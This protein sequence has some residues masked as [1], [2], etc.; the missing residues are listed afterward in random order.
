ME[1]VRLE[2]DDPRPPL[3]CGDP[4]LDE[5]YAVD[6]I[7]GCRELLSVTYVFCEDSAAIA[8][9]SLSND[10]IKKEEVPRSSFERLQKALKRE[11]RYRSMPAAKIGRIGVSCELQSKGIGTE[12]LDFLKA[13]FTQG[14]KTGCRFLI[15][16]AYNTERATR[17]Y[18]KNGFQ[19]LTVNDQNDATRI[20]YFD[21][22]TF[23]P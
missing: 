11:K 5:F 13:W 18:E 1:L 12:V 10:A 6:S 22:K 4:D 14:N 17:F 9:F 7:V 21:L 8:Y 23:R 3:V 20:M 2:A 16:D 15:V 19:F